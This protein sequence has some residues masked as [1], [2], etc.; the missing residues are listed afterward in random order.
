MID[1][2]YKCLKNHVLIKDYK[3]LL[4]KCVKSQNIQ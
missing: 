2:R 1:K 4:V 3:Q